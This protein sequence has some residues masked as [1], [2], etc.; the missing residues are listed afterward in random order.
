MSCHSCSYQTEENQSNMKRKA[1]K[2]SNPGGGDA[3]ISDSFTQPSGYC[4]R[5]MMWPVA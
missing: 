5:V 2:Q 3:S 4:C 1:T